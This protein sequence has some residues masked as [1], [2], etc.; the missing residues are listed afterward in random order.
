ML[1]THLKNIEGREVVPGYYGQFIHS[2]TMTV[3]HWHI[4]AHHEMPEHAHPHEQIFNL[5]E[6]TFELTVAG[7]TV[8]AEPGTVVIIPPN[9]KHSGRS[10]STCRVIDIFYPVRK[11][12]Q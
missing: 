2:E 3:A 10:L 5:F 9:V 8:V 7:E 1:H 11:E 4:E 6:G 12:Y